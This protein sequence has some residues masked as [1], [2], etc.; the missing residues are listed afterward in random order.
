MAPNL[1]QRRLGFTLVEMLVTVSIIGILT[2]ISVPSY[3]RQQAR[4]RQ[5]EAK[6][7]LA[8]IYEVE[9]AFHGANGTYTTCLKQL[10]VDL[11]GSARRYYAVGFNY[12]GSFAG[13]YDGCTTGGTATS[14]C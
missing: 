7:A 10:G 12:A 9:Q 5:Q 6:S 13:R 3:R 1:A 8:S 2:A 4:S 14:A 11:N